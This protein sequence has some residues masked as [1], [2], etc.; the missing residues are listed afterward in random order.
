M[1][2]LLPQNDPCIGIYALQRWAALAVSSDTGSYGKKKLLKQAVE[3]YEQFLARAEAN[4]VPRKLI[5]SVNST[6]RTLKMFS[7]GNGFGR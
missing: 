3:R 5:D 7:E 2:A 6:V 4:D 1:I